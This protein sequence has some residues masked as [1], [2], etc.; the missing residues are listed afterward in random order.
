MASWAVGA[1]RVGLRCVGVR[2]GLLSQSGFAE[3]SRVRV[4]CARDRLGSLGKDR[5]L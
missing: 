1:M 5:W 3:V 4:S 2:N